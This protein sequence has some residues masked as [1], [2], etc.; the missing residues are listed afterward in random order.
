MPAVS[1]G[2]EDAPA[3]LAEALARPA[4]KTGWACA[5][6]GDGGV[7]VL[8]DAANRIAE[9]ELKIA[10]VGGCEVLYS[11]R[12]ARAAGIDLETRWTPGG[13]SLRFLADGP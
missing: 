6:G 12:R 7:Q 10:L 2:Y 3:R 4:P 8:S 9:G 5:A 13:S 11:R 1:W